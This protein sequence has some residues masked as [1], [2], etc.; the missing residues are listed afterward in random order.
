MKT[1]KTVANQAKEKLI[2]KIIN[3]CK[4]CKIAIKALAT[5][6]TLQFIA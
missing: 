4:I 2:I 5:T 3:I 1:T 6:I